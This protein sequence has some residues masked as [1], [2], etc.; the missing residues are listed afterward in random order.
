MKTI[1]SAKFLTSFCDT[2][3]NMYRLG[4]DERNGGN[5]SMLLD[6]DEVREHLDTAHVI[7]KIPFMGVKAASFDASPLAGRIFLVTG[8]GKYFKN[9]KDDPEGN[10]AGY[11]RGLGQMYVDD[12]RFGANYGGAV[13]AELVRDSLDRWLE[14]HGL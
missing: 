8:T 9:I 14:A 2:A 6:E 4:W 5:I 3:A 1:E 7:R 11:V 12:P 13:G 10:L